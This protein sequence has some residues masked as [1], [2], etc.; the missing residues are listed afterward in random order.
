MNEYKYVTVSDIELATHWIPLND[1]RYE[2]GNLKKICRYIS[3]LFTGKKYSTDERII[4]DVPYRLFDCREDGELVII[5]NTGHDINL[6][7]CHFGYFVKRE[8]I[9]D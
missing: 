7:L 8:L 4:L 6:W 1:S 9:V 2:C 3:S 5:D